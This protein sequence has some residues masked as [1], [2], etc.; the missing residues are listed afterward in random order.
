MVR[1]SQGFKNQ[2][3]KPSKIVHPNTG[4]MTD[5][6]LRTEYT[7]LSKVANKRINAINKAGYYSPAVARLNDRGISKFGLKNQ[8]LTSTSDI[9]KAMRELTNFLNADTSTRTGIRSVS[10]QITNNFGITNNGNYAEFTKKTRKIFDLYEDLH[11]LQQ[12]GDLKSG[13]KYDMVNDLGTLY[14][15]GLIDENTTTGDLIQLLQDMV[16]Q[17]KQNVRNR[18]TQLNFNWFV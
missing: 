4:R 6:Q 17:R 13:D 9:K 8:G 5:A 11:E 10:D 18:Y 16:E 15:A 12:H 14:D 7:R 3:F 1:L 2:M